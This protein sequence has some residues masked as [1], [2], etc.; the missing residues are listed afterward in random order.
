[1]SHHKELQQVDHAFGEE[2]ILPTRLR[3]MLLPAVLLWLWQAPT[4]ALDIGPL[5]DTCPQHDPVYSQM[6]TGIDISDTAANS[7]C[8]KILDGVVFQIWT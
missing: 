2:A 6:M 7:S 8:Y 4:W 5:L 1:M 3:L